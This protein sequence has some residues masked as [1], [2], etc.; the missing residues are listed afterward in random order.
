MEVWIETLHS[1]FY[2]FTHLV[3]SHVEVWIETL[4]YSLTYSVTSHVEVWIETYVSRIVSSGH[5]VTSHVE[6]CIET[7]QTL[8][9]IR[10]YFGVTSHVEVWIETPPYFINHRLIQSP[11]TWR[12]GLKLQSDS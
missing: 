1:F 12:C 8:N 2:H 10:K 9:Q 3:T 11:P 5:S 4:T 7:L 6:V